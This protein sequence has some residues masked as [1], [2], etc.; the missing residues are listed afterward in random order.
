MLLR[1]FQQKAVLVILWSICVACTES[2]P[3]Y[4][5]KC[6]TDASIERLLPANSLAIENKSPIVATVDDIPIYKSDV[7]T[8]LSKLSPALRNE[9]RTSREKDDF[10]QTL[11]NK[12]L[13]MIE[14]R[15]KG[16]EQRLDIRSKV[17]EYEQRLIIRTLMSEL[18]AEL[19]EDTAKAH[20]DSHLARYQK[21]NVY[22]LAR[23][24]RLHDGQEKSKSQAKRAIERDL[25]Q[26]Q[27]GKSFE[28]IAKTADGPER[29][30]GGRLGAAPLKKI[31]ALKTRRAIREIREPGQWT[32]A[33]STKDGYEIYTL[34]SIE[35]G[36]VRKFSEVKD[37]ILAELQS[38]RHR[39]VFDEL[40][41]KLKTTSRIE[42]Y[43]DAL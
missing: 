39:E 3:D 35:P 41:R 24:Q 28:V 14:A 4:A 33:L 32:S 12:K 1:C 43:Q 15:R 27:E 29:L 19:G 6:S 36:E 18:N 26:L 16:I 25:K 11:I 31:A 22:Q 8:E 20:Y 17:A 40:L 21:P 9:F 23:I 5:S 13:L 34:I 42:I 30:R 37:E 7:D 2:I 10:V 38:A